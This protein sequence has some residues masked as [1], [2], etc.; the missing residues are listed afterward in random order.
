[1]NRRALLISNPGEPGTE[2][3]LEG[4]ALDIRNYRRFLRSA[5]GGLWFDDE[6]RSLFQPS[7]RTVRNEIEGVAECDYALIVFS[8]HGG[9]DE[10]RRSTMVEI[11]SGHLFDVS[12]FLGANPRLTLVIDS[13]R[14]TIMPSPVLETFAAKTAA[15]GPRINPQECRKYYDEQI[16]ECG[17][18]LV[19]AYACAVGQ[20]A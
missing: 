4:T 16:E 9:Y 13:C 19:V 17:D 5:I 11:S 20:R 3:Y 7:I 14:E 8:G 1:M 15:A 6:I 18:D 2:D 12:D 10:D